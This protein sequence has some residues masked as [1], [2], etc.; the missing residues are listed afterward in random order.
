MNDEIECMCMSVAGVTFKVKGQ[1]SNKEAGIINNNRLHFLD[2][3]QK[4]RSSPSN[5]FYGRKGLAHV[6]PKY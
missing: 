1:T 6:L 5:T 2:L 3:V 4:T